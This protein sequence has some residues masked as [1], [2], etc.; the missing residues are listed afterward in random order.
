MENTKITMDDVRGE[1]IA[2]RSALNLIN[3]TLFNP[4]E[5]IAEEEIETIEVLEGIRGVNINVIEKV[6]NL[7]NSLEKSNFK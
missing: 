4:G 6:S 7:V 2:I 3:A 1:L 5:V